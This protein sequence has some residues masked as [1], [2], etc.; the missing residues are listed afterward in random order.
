MNFADKD[1]DRATL[2][3]VAA[4]LNKFFN[5]PEDANIG[6]CLCVFPKGKGEVFKY[7]S[8]ASRQDVLNMMNAAINRFDSVKPLH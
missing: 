2:R 4:I 1:A 6:F 5:S 7:I 8:N 3:Q